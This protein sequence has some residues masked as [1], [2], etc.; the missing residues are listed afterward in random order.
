L[1]RLDQLPARRNDR[2]PAHPPATPI[3]RLPARTC[4]VK[5][6]WLGVYSSLAAIDSIKDTS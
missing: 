2:L 4:F 1:S 5:T 6:Q 3:S